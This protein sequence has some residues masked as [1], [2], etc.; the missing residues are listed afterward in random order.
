MK[1][2]SRGIEAVKQMLR[3][4]AQIKS[5]RDNIDSMSREPADSPVANENKRLLLEKILSLLSFMQNV[6]DPEGRARQLPDYETFSPEEVNLSL[7]ELLFMFQQT[8]IQLQQMPQKVQ[9]NAIAILYSYFIELQ[10]L[11]DLTVVS[12]S[13]T[14]YSL[15]PLTA[16]TIA[17]HQRRYFQL[18][19]EIEN[20]PLIQEYRSIKYHF[21]MKGSL[22]HHLYV[23]AFDLLPH[24]WLLK[25]KEFVQKTPKCR[26]ILDPSRIT[27]V[28]ELRSALRSHPLSKSEKLRVA[29]HRHAMRMFD[30]VFT[31][32]ALRIG[33][34]VFDALVLSIWIQTVKDHVVPGIHRKDW[35]A[36]SLYEE[37]EQE[38]VDIQ[39]G[40]GKIKMSSAFFM[41]P[42]VTFNLERFL[43]FKIRTMT[44]GDVVRV[45][46]LGNWMRQNSPDEFLQF[47]NIAMGDMGG[48]GIRTM[49]EHEIV[50]TKE[51][52]WLYGALMSFVPG[53][54]TSPGS[55]SMR[56]TNYGL[57]K[58]QQLFQEILF[59][60]PRFKG[61]SGLFSD[62]GIMLKSLGV[63]RKGRVG[64]A[65]KQTES[66]D[67]KKRGF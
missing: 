41:Q 28:E 37:R 31:R 1:K 8:L 25:I 47:F 42:R 52:E 32:L 16:S 3:L 22:A 20:D 48:L 5:I 39:N 13:G 60:D 26:R 46:E 27:S 21:L 51:T 50:Q 18:S 6:I 59:Y 58:A 61:S 11:Y 33:R 55:I 14:H 23:I 35:Q 4:K 65:L 9:D 43:I 44:V 30:I 66:F 40:P 63:L 62:F 54:M 2:L 67:G 45:T 19:E 7:A 53:G 29:I 38:V 36:E 57:T 64:Q 56:K 24:Y 12:A 15:T 49:P 17:E 10:G 34:P